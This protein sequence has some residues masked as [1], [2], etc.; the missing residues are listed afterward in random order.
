MPPKKRFA[1][2]PPVRIAPLGEVRAYTVYEHEL[3][4]LAQG[5]G[6]SLWLNFALALI[7]TAVGIVATMRSSQLID[8][9]FLLFAGVAVIFLLVGAICLAVWGVTHTSSRRQ[10]R[11]IK[12]RM[13]PPVLPSQPLQPPPS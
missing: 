7:P 13:P 3:D 2:Q 11:A 8:I 10:L 12:D 9:N 6:G 5:G 4:A 1:D